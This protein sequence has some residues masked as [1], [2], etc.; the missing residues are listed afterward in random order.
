MPACFSSSLILP[1]SGV[2]IPLNLTVRTHSS[3]C[4]PCH[5]AYG[6]YNPG[7]VRRADCLLCCQLHVVVY[8]SGSVLHQLVVTACQQRCQSQASNKT[9]YSMGQPQKTNKIWHIFRRKG[10]SRQM[11]RSL[12]ER[13]RLYNTIAIQL[14]GV[15]QGFDTKHTHTQRVSDRSR[16]SL[17]QDCLWK[18]KVHQQTTAQ[19]CVREPKCCSQN[20][21]LL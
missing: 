1:P 20:P 10:V 7:S 14:H 5:T 15:Q 17:R 12:H 13:K 2:S 8:E 16:R 19:P 18:V 3:I 6:V 4:F 9:A 21:S 11:P